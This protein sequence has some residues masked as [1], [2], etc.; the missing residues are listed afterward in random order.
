MNRS[1]KA[2]ALAAFALAAAFGAT[3]AQASANNFSVNFKIKNAE[4]VNSDNMIRTSSLPSTVT[5]LINPPANIAPQAFD[6]NSGTALYSDTLPLPGQTAHVDMS[7]ANASD[8]VSNQCTFT[9]TVGHDSNVLQPYYV[10][11]S[12]NGASRC[13]IPGDA[14]S[15]NGVFSGTFTLSWAK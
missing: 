5:G 1:I 13:V 12:N 4:P 10:H 6:P 7:Y 15:S 3:T 14:R 2:L 11:F 8:G 9:I